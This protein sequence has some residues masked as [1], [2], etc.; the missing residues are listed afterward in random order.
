MRLHLCLREATGLRHRPREAM[1]GH[2]L[3]AMGLRPLLDVSH[4]R[5]YHLATVVNRSMELH[6]LQDV[7]H[8]RGSHLA[9][10][11]NRSMELRQLQDVSHTK[12][13]HLATVVSRSRRQLRQL[14]GAS[15]TRGSHL[16]TAASL[17]SHSSSFGR[18]P[19]HMEAISE[20]PQV[21]HLRQLQAWQSARHPTP[22]GWLDLEVQAR[23]THQHQGACKRGIYHLCPDLN[24]CYHQARHTLKPEATCLPCPKF[25]RQAH[26]T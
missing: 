6:Q 7:L 10:V 4:I 1:E 21:L 16:A 5:G 18:H 26:L 8:T 3:Q 24:I 17:S 15:V 11:A 20:F 19:L 2:Q 25:V 14:Q 12:G 23:K 13:S 22:K 9:T